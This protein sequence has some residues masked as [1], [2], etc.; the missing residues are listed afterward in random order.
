[1]AGELILSSN[2]EVKRKVLT[3]PHLAHLDRNVPNFLISDLTG[4]SDKDDA[5]VITLTVHSDTAPSHSPKKH[6]TLENDNENRSTLEAWVTQRLL[7]D[8]VSTF[9][10]VAFV[11]KQDPNKAS[12]SAAAWDNILIAFLKDAGIEMEERPHFDLRPSGRIYYKGSNDQVTALK[13]Y[14]LKKNYIFTE[15]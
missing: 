13:N 1:M 2:S 5:Y 4:L 12:I 9:D 14:L 8:I 10:L 15:K 11:A 7:D 6:W 3:F